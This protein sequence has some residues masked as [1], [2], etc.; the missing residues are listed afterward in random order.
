VLSKGTVLKDRIRCAYYSTQSFEQHINKLI[1]QKC[2]NVIK[3]IGQPSVNVKRI[4]WETICKA[5]ESIVEEQS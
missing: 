1:G 2:V 3:N 5:K 4:V